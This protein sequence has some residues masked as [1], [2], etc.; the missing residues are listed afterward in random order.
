MNL[1]NRLTFSLASIFLLLAFAA[2][3]AMAQTISAIWTDDLNDDN[4]ADDPGWNVTIGGLSDNAA[5]TNDSATVT[6]LDVNGTTAATA[7]G[8]TGLTSEAVADSATEVEGTIAAALGLQIAVAVTVTNDDGTTNYQR[9]T[10]PVAGPNAEVESMDLALLPMLAD[11][12]TPLYY[13]QFGDMVTVTFN[14]ATP[15]ATDPTI[16]NP[17][18][19]LHVSDVTLGTAASWQYISVSK[20]DTAMTR[21]ITYRSTHTADAASVTTTV[22][23]GAAFAQPTDPAT[24]GQATIHYDNTAPTVTTRT[25][26][27]IVVSAPPGSPSPPDGVWGGDFP[28]FNLT[29]SVSDDGTGSGLPDTNPVRIDTDTDKLEVVVIGLAPEDGTIDGTEYLVQ[30]RPI[31]GRA[32]T[33]GEEVV[34][35]VV[36][37]DKAGNEGSSAISVKLAMSVPADALYQ[38]AA[39]ASGNVMR[40]GTITVTFDKDPG[41]VMATGAAVSGTGNTRTLTVDAAQAAGALSVTLTWGQSGRQVLSYT[42]VIPD[43]PA[44]AY[45]SADP[46]VDSSIDPGDTI[47]LTFAADPGTVTTS[48]GTISGTGATRMIA[49]PADQAAGALTITVSWTMAGREDGSQMLTYTVTAPFVSQNPTAPANISM[50]IMIPANS[51]VVVVR[52][53]AMANSLSAAINFPMVDG[54]DVMIREWSKMPDLEALFNRSSYGQGGALVLRKSAD[55]RDNDM[56][57]ADGNNI[58]TYA[59][60]ALGSVGISEI[61]WGLDLGQVNRDTWKVGQW[62]ELHNLNSKPVN[63]LLYAQT[64]RELVNNQLVDITATGDS[65]AGGLGGM[66]IDVVQNIN[67]EGNQGKGGWTLPGKSGNSL[68]GENL[69]GAHRIL[70]D[71]QPAYSAAQNYTKRDGRNSGH[72]RAATNVYASKEISRTVNQVTTIVVADYVGTPGSRNDFTGISLLRPAGLTGVS[73]AITINEVGNNSNNA[74]DWIELKG[75]AGTNLRNYMISIVTQTDSDVPLIQFSA[76]DNAKIAANGHFLILNTDPAND[77][78]HPIAGTGYNV[79]L[80]AELQRPGTLNSRTGEQNTPVRYKVFSGLNLPND[81]KF[82]LILRRPDN[83][84]GHRSGADGG[85]GVAETGNADLDKVVDV[86]GWDD[87][88]GKSNYPNS[89]S[90]TG[91]WPLHSFGGPFTNRNAF[92][93]NTVHRRQFVTT[94]DGR[95]GI[96]A[97]ENKNQDDRAAFRDVGYTGVGYRSAAAVSAAHGGTPGYANDTF[98]SN[99]GTV[100]SS[101]YISEIMYADNEA[102]VLPQWIELRNTSKSIGV[103]LHD[104]RLTITNHADMADGTAWKGKGEGSVQLRNMRIKPNS[105]VLIASRRAVQRLGVPTVHMPDSD[106]FILYAHKAAFGMTTINDDVIN[107]YGFKIHLEAKVGNAWQTL[108]VVGNLNSAAKD[109]RGRSDERFAAPLWTWPTGPEANGPRVS[110]VRNAWRKTPTSAMT[111]AKGTSDWGWELSTADPGHTRV[112]AIT[113]Y[114]DITDISTPGLTH[115]QPLPV[116]LSFFRPALEDGKVVIRWTTESELDNAGFNVYRSESRNGEFKQVN[117]KLIQ[118]K[119]TT[120]E[121]STYKWVDTS[122]KPGAIYYYQIEDVS[123]AGERSTLTTTK[124]KGLISAKNKLTTKWGELKEV[125]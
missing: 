99:G 90:N 77:P 74:Y 55:A 110:V 20:D 93:Q 111:I 48:V 17:V 12:T 39:P 68:T 4:T 61:M 29:F 32:T 117:D 119:G 92:W 5:A 76:N 1:S 95:S 56:Q 27:D 3:P 59:T 10:F 96:G 44:I 85:K 57:D 7:T 82:V 108:D 88:V 33:A 13:A 71:K 104:A 18:A 30:I 72:W 114:G 45:S 62:I 94:N 60:P 103:N 91:L 124:L 70:P 123:F 50:P 37:V 116:S 53:E 47:T 75:A 22:D 97:H 28:L 35:T 34:I 54:Q 38:S 19:D 49:I 25:G 86:A 2:V 73:H 8:V 24:D 115:G 109:D 121:R 113:Y 6:F 83:H 84:E 106:I 36:P 14:F 102:G 40:S 67:N 46:V 105:S 80:S 15:P 31:V 64:A 51:Y 52:D 65:I 100:Q 89:I 125:Q 43:D 66:V 63:V 26:G 69:I 41:T 42:V 118:G 122:A 112:A 16:G 9:V 81:G 87:N 58:G 78:N 11:L 101:V 98:Q 23:I 120:A 79:D 107:T 21:S